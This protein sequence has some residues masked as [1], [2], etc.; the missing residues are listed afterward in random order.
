MRDEEVYLF[1]HSDRSEESLFGSVVLQ[2]CEVGDASSACRLPQHDRTGMRD[3]EV[4]L[5]CHSDRS[6]ESLFG[7]VVLQSCEVGDASSACWLPHHDKNR[8]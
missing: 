7:S 4:Y 8:M 3:E 2:S 1:C 5:F 6:E